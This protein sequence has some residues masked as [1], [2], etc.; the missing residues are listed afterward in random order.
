ME[1]KRT[2]RMPKPRARQLALAAAFL[3]FP[4]SESVIQSF[5]TAGL[6]SLADHDETFKVAMLRAAGVDWDEIDR[7]TRESVNARSS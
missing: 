7:I 2:I 6:L 4:D 1:S 3:G 5:I